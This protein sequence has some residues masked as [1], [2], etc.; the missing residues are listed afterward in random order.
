M[1]WQ[2]ILGKLKSEKPCMLLQVAESQ[3][4]SPGR[5][6][7]RMAVSIDGEMW[8]SIGG[9]IMEHKLVTLAI[10]LLKKGSI[11]VLCKQQIHNKT[12][13][14][15]QSG[16]I[17][18]G[19]Q[20]IIILPLTKKESPIIEAIANSMRSTN[21]SH[22]VLNAKGIE[23]KTSAMEAPPFMTS[24]LDKTNWAYAEKLHRK[25]IVHIIG[26][27]HVGLAFSRQM[28]LLDFH[29]CIYDNRP[30]LNTMI[31]NASADEK[32]VIDYAE[33]DRYIT[34]GEQHFVVIMSFGYRDDKQILKAL[35]K[36]QFGY[37]GMM[38]SKAKIKQLLEELEAEGISRDKIAHVRTPIGID[39]GSETPAEIAVSIAAEII[40]KRKSRT[41]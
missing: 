17:C 14:Q 21:E 39:I 16:M 23:L 37:I 24:N 29:V 11:D 34:E 41:P 13:K 18:S 8:G 36:K 3:G 26:A 19:E 4:S 35:Y 40:A 15:N 25:R 31:K 22:I 9:G 38:G 7:F 30:E 12:N 28:S 32:Q 20:T 2:F 5:Q 33:V 10:D 27:G 1:I 6:G